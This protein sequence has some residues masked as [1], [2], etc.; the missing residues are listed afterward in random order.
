MSRSSANC[1]VMA[2][3]PNELPEVIVVRPLI[4]PNWRSK[5]VVTDETITSGP[6]PGNCAVTWI[7]GKS[8]GGSAEI[9]SDE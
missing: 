2:A 7:V 3:L 9:G 6:A 5:G 8:T 1:N 4:W